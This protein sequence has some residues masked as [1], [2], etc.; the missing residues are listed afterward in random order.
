MVNGKATVN[1]PD[2]SEGSHNV[3]VTYSG[4]AKY[5]S[6]VKNSVIN[7]LPIKLKGFNLA[8]LYT[9][10][11]YYKVRLTQGTHALAGKSVKIIINGKTYKRTTDV[12]HLED[13]LQAGIG[14]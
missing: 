1:V 10:G 3:T 13:G 7:I 6:I 2:L 8:M 5:A 11:K 4:D 9:S 14:R 12:A